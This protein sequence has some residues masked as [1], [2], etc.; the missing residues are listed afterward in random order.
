MATCSHFCRELANKSEKMYEEC[1]NTEKEDK[2][3]YR[4]ASPSLDFEEISSIPK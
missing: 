1:L 4:A 3:A 2:S